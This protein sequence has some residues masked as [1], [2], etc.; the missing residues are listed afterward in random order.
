MFEKIDL[1]VNGFY[2]CSTNQSKT[3]KKAKARFEKSEWY[4]GGKIKAKFA[5][6]KAHRVKCS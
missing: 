4:E 5:E 6:S 2:V 1:Y 3:L